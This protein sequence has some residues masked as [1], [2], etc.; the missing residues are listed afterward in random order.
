MRN[1]TNQ[2]SQLRALRRLLRSFRFRLTLLFVAI[3]AL[4]LA[5]F[6]ITIY[7][8][9]ARILYAEAAERLS[10]QSAQLAA[11]YSAQLRSIAEASEGHPVGIPPGELPLL[12]ED[13]TLALVGLDGKVALQQG[14]LQQQVLTAMLKAWNASP[15]SQEPLVFSLPGEA[16]SSK[17]LFQVNPLRVEGRWSG[18]LILIN[19]LSSV[20]P[21]QRLAISLALSSLFILLIAFAGGYWLADRAMKPVQTIVHTARSI[22]ENDL[23]Q[24][25]NLNR[26]DEIGELADTFDQMLERLQAAFE[27]QRQFTADASHELRSPLAIIELESNR[28]LERPRTSKEYEQALR[29]I[30]SENERMSVLVNEML[31]LARLDSGKTAMRAE[32]LDL[33]DIA[34]EVTERLTPL[35]Q[36]RG[37][38]IKTGSLLECYVQADRIYLT[39]LLTNLVE[40]AIKYTQRDDAQVLVETGT[41][42]LDGKPW[43]QA[44]ISDNG[45][46]IPAE[47]LSHIFDRFYRLDEARTSQ[48]NEEGAPVP[49][50]GLGLAI[51]SSIAE[52]FGGRIEVQSR[53]G[54]G[55]TFTIWLPG[56]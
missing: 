19:P 46:G 21:L 8:R 22:S 36:A 18:Y 2:P 45:S 35:A 56:N 52:A 6:S 49:G 47:H 42:V 48:E 51:A 15:V 12:Q 39:Q 40:N 34:V 25:L 17:Y 37:V 14:K 16:N 38:V 50:S 33:S 28:S 41:Q 29:L 20:V 4:I 31:L 13:A 44:R 26:E 23:S 10:T 3:L 7:T 9:Q 55:T 5:G 27:R 53:V 11:Y 54:D 32:R 1:T 24:R 30:Q 43:S